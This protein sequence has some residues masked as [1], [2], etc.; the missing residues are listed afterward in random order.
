MPCKN[1][2]LTEHNYQKIMEELVVNY[3]LIAED[4]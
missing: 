3:E 1:K 4:Y 2:A